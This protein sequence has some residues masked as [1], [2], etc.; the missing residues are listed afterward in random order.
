MKSFTFQKRQKIDTCVTTSK[1]TFAQSKCFSPKHNLPVRENN[2]LEQ[3]AFWHEVKVV[4]CL[5]NPPF[6]HH[7]STINYYWSI[8]HCLL[9]LLS[10]KS[11]FSTISVFVHFSLFK[12]KCPWTR[13]MTGG[14]WT[15]SMKVV[16]GPGF[17]VGV[18]G[19]LV[20]VLSSPFG[21][22]SH[23]KSGRVGMYARHK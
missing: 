20:H 14:P 22:I 13:S 4:S 15:W 7:E 6:L 23:I 11:Y 10:F 2:L 18:H 17:K 16:H 8:E 3:A 1:F 9:L 12:K 5:L 19:P 21:R